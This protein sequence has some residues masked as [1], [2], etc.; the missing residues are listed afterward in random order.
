MH[1]QAC[2]LLNLYQRDCQQV[3]GRPAR[4]KTSQGG[5]L[6][7][8]PASQA[9]RTHASCARARREERAASSFS[10]QIHCSRKTLHCP[11]RRVEGGQSTKLVDFLPQKNR[12]DTYPITST[13]TLRSKDEQKTFP[14]EANFPGLKTWT[15]NI[16]IW[17]SFP[18]WCPLP[19]PS[20]PMS[21][22]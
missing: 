12:P 20:R 8:T 14:S 5:P 21:S 1:L 15:P 13:P 4:L 18:K 19:Y 2:S 9:S 7:P 16:A 11:G 17:T 6:H 10:S 3:R 22:Y